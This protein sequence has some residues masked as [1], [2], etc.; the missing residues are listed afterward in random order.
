MKFIYAAVFRI[1]YLNWSKFYQFLQR[2]FTY[3]YKD[4]VT[5]VKNMLQYISKE[6]PHPQKRYKKVW[7]TYRIKWKRDAW[8]MLWDVISDPY[9]IL[10]R[11]DDCENFALLSYKLYGDEIIYREKSDINYDLYDEAKYKFE[12]FYFMMFA[13][14]P[15]G[16]GH[17]VAVWKNEKGNIWLVSNKE[18]LWFEKESDIYIWA[19]YWGEV[20]YVVEV[21]GDLHYIRTRSV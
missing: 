19:K 3:K 12:S 5:R 2:L 20:K 9:L 17:C 6:Y 10:T 8:Y 11:G 15:T 1:Y 21:T 16:G 4:K 14:I 7:E 13:P 18:I